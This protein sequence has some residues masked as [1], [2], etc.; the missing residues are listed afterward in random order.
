MDEKQKEEI[1]KKIY[2]NVS[3]KWMSTPNIKL[4]D[5]LDSIYQS[6]MT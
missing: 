3:N 2:G 4:E 1:I 6:I 5:I